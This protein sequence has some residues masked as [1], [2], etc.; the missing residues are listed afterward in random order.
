MPRHGLFLESLH[1]QVSLGAEYASVLMV[2]DRS[3]VAFCLHVLWEVFGH[4]SEGIFNA[5]MQLAL[6]TW[7][8]SL[9]HYNLASI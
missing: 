8:H 4:A 7:P 1:H 3:G 6:Q 2:R 9:V 5:A